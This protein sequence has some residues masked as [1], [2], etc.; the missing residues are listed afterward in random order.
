[1][2]GSPSLSIQNSTGLIDTVAK[3]A[4][5]ALLESIGCDTASDVVECLRGVNATEL[6]A[7][8]T[9]LSTTYSP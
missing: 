9:N 8:Q 2:S 1:M 4:W 7:I 6:L 5:D 3:P